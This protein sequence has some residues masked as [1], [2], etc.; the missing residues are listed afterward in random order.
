M[1]LLPE[2][3]EPVDSRVTEESTEDSEIDSGSAVGKHGSVSGKSLGKGR[4]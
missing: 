3:P 1:I 2:H 4:K